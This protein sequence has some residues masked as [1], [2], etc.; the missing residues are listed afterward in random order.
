[1]CPH[2]EADLCDGKTGRLERAVGCLR[3]RKT[4]ADFAL[5][6]RQR[7]RKTR[8]PAP[9]R[10]RLGPGTTLTLAS[11]I[12]ARRI[13]QADILLRPL[14]KQPL[15]RS[16]RKEL[17]ARALRRGTSSRTSRVFQRLGFK[18]LLNRKVAA[19]T[20]PSWKRRDTRPNQPCESPPT[21]YQD[22]DPMRVMLQKTAAR[23]LFVS[24]R[25]LTPGLTRTSLPLEGL[26][27]INRSSQPANEISK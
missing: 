22:N 8:R 6:S 11:R 26:A 20:I 18:P 19:S 17:E 24:R 5:G 13:S 27:G 16:Q 12:R 2:W 3:P 15:N 25:N 21:G 14:P 7:L 9:K 10:L 4:G 23:R 1:M